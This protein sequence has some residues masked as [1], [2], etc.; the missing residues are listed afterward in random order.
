MS[1]RT[2]VTVTILISLLPLGAVSEPANGRTVPDLIVTDQKTYAD[3]TLEM[4]NIVVETGGSLTFINC[5][6]NMSVG[7]HVDITVRQGGNLTIR[8]CMFRAEYGRSYGFI[9][10][11]GLEITNSTI[12]DT[13]TY[14]YG[15]GVSSSGMTLYSS[16]C[17][18]S[19]SIVGISYGASM[20]L[21]GGEPLL[22]RNTFYADK[23]C[24]ADLV[25]VNQGMPVFESNIFEGGR[26]RGGRFGTMARRCHRPRHG[27]QRQ[28]E[29]LE[30]FV[31]QLRRRGA[32]HHTHRLRQWRP[33][34]GQGRCRPGRCR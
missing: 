32:V 23:N 19:D 28:R 26:Q 24:W 14:I 33:G 31:H 1:W 25:V 20:Y 11:G 17:S 27:L 21:T 9:S 2:L 29:D 10:W 34:T 13:G 16:N 6:V 3:Q 12:L 22:A 15:G 5:T 8:R 7:A 4:G 18:I 30:Q